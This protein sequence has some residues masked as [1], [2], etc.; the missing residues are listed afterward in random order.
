ML[1]PQI[2]LAHRLIGYALLMIIRT[3]LVGQI[4]KGPQ[5]NDVTVVQK[6]YLDYNVHVNKWG[7]KGT[8]VDE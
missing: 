2:S 7:N 6:L 5:G 3:T 1:V 8:Y 4:C